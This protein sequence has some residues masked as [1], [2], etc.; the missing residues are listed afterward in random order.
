MA[1]LRKMAFA[2]S[3]ANT[4]SPTITVLAAVATFLTLTANGADITASQA[5]TLFSV[6][7][8][9]QFTIG[10]S[11]KPGGGASALPI[12]GTTKRSA[13]THKICVSSP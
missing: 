2:S 3:A 8:A 10:L 11:L 12:F 13:Y 1:G 6:F 7:I 9:L 5:F 4:V